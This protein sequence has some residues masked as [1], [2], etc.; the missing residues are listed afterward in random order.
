MAAAAAVEGCIV[1]AVGAACLLASN[2][3]FRLPSRLAEVERFGA[4]EGAF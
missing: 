4:E 3:A 1:A 2:G